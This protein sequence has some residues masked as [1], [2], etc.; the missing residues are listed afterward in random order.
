[1]YPSWV[2]TGMGTCPSLT[3]LGWGLGPGMRWM[4]ILYVK[5]L[6]Q[7]KFDIEILTESLIPQWKNNISMS[8]SRFLHW[9]RKLFEKNIFSCQKWPKK[10]D[11]KIYFLHWGRNIWMSKPKNILSLKHLKPWRKHNFWRN[12]FGVREPYFD[13]KFI[14]ICQNSIFMSKNILVFKHLQTSK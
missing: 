2:G 14:F 8:N 1:M 5:L 7:T 9:G 6:G 11:M 12:F 10:F 4:S 13:V 3:T